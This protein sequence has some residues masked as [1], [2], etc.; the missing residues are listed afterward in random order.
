MC[1]LSFLKKEVTSHSLSRKVLLPLTVILLLISSFTGNPVQACENPTDS[2]DNGNMSVYLDFHYHNQYIR[3]SLPTINFVRDRQL[4]QVHVKITRHGAG[5]AGA[6]YVMSFVGRE[7]FEDMNNEITY[8][9]PASNSDDDTRQG[10]LKRLKI[11]LGPYLANSGMGEHISFNIDDSLAGQWKN[12]IDDPWKNW[13]FE[14]YGGANYYKES[15]QSKFNSRW[16]FFADKVSEDWKVR[17]RPYFNINESSFST[18]DK[19][20]IVSEN[21]RHGFDGFVIRSLSPHWSAGLFVDMLASTFH[22]MEFNIEAAPGIEYSLFP[23]SESTRKAITFA[24]TLGGARNYY[25]E[26]TIF[27]KK[28]ENLFKQALD[29]SLSFDQPW[30]EIRGGVEGS[31]YFHDFNANRL[32]MYSRFD[33]NL[34]EGLSLNFFGDFE[35][36]NDL[37]TI[38]AGDASLEEILLEERERATSYQI[39]TSIGLTYQFGSEFSNVVNTRF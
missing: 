3:E 21:Y 37:L 22:N 39:F 2:S 9:A 20:D 31:H 23:Y 11:G 16:G 13:V 33:L 4:S 15:S 12:E 26:E 27:F 32:E 7:Q 25:M 30:G 8:W 6:N 1:M 14:I 10:L 19:D 35:L 28:Q 5:S 17:I 29:I 34:I 18:D 36:I 38:P 24:Y